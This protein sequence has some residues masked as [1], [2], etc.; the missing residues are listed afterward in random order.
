ME[1]KKIINEL[2]KLDTKEE[3]IAKLR[4]LRKENV[5]HAGD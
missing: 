1:T 5:N 4:E 2:L 3:I